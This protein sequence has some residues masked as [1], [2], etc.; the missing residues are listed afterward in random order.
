VCCVDDVSEVHTASIS[1]GQFYEQKDEVA[2]GSTLSYAI[3]NYM[4]HFNEWPLDTSHL[5]A[6][7]LGQV[8]G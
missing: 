6:Y 4:E 7:M 5:K 3:A 2:V 8:H 1:D